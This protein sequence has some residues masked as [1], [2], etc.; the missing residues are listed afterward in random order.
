MLHFIF[1]I[2]IS[3]KEAITAAWGMLFK[4]SVNKKEREFI[5]HLCAMETLFLFYDETFNIEANH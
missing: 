5:L 1:H 4:M 3:H 2:L